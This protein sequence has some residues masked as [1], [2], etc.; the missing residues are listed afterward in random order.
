MR[1]PLVLIPGIQGRWEYLQPAIEALSADFDVIAFQLCGERGCREPHADAGI[2]RY[3]ALVEHELDE[4]QIDRAIVCGVSFG[5]VVAMRFAATHPERTR[6]LVLASVPGPGWH[7]RK[8]H[9]FYARFPRVFGAAF[10]AES[11]FRLRPEISAALSGPAWRRHVGWQLRTLVTAPLSPKRM[12]A[13][14]RLMAALD[15]SADAKRIV[16]P[17]LIVTG[18]PALDRV[19]PVGATRQY[20]DLIRGAESAVIDRTGHQGTITRP[21]EFARILRE[22]VERH[23][24]KDRS[25]ASA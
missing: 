12:A 23:D 3:A 2:D 18:E 20:L 19:V 21:H 11:P 22:F 9:D 13:R 25:R 8:R 6:A 24:E 16:A 5:G 1:P 10:L 14:A 4:R 7:L 15:T 17:T